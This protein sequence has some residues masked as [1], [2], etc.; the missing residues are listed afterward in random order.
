ME[1]VVLPLLTGSLSSP[2]DIH[3]APVSHTGIEG[4][5]GSLKEKK[6]KE[7]ERKGKN[8]KKSKNM[9]RV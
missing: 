8:R 4:C 5:H 7:G 6:K 2:Q 1:L 3:S 9:E